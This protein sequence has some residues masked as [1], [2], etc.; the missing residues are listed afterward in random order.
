MLTGNLTASFN[1]KLVLSNGLSISP[2]KQSG[3]SRSL[4][5]SILAINNE[6]DLS[7][8]LSNQHSK[9]PPR[10]G[11]AKYEKNHVSL[12]LL[13]Q[14]PSLTVSASRPSTPG[15]AHC[16]PTP[17][18]APAAEHRS[19]STTPVRHVPELPVKHLFGASRPPIQPGTSSRTQLWP[20]HG[21][22]SSVGRAAAT[23]FSAAA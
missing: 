14:W 22:H 2:L 23:P 12:L 7:D 20:E 18:A 5:E 15:A 19:A 16:C 4:R 17:A 3:E 6:K 8:Y 21:R 11:P 9:L 13:L 1:E 10:T